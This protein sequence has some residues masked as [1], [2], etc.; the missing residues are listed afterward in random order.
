MKRA[1]ADTDW[2]KSCQVR[3]VSD[4]GNEVELD[5]CRFRKIRYS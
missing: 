1:F 5:Q 4:R 2:P 3:S